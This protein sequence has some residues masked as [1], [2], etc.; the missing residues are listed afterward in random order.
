MATVTAKNCMNGSSFL[1][2]FTG[3]LPALFL[4]LFRLIDF[5]GTVLLPSLF[6][7]ARSKA[8]PPPRKQGR[9]TPEKLPEQP[10]LAGDVGSNCSAH[11]SSSSSS[12]RDSPPPSSFQSDPA[13]ILFPPFP[14]FLFFFLGGSQGHEPTT[15]FMNSTY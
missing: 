3:F 13:V 7:P 2:P 10:G 8:T 1:P 15:L 6:S 4:L 9:G 14:P 11:S 5:Q 12:R